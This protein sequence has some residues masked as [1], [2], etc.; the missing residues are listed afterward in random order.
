MPSIMVPMEA[1]RR[2]QPRMEKASSFGLLSPSWFESSTRAICSFSDSGRRKE[3]PALQSAA[4]S[5]LP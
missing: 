2:L 5:L 4:W 1:T 3:A